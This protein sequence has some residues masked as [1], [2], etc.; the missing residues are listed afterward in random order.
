MPIPIAAAIAGGA[1]LGSAGINAYS[2]GKTNKATRNYNTQMYNKQRADSMFDWMMQNKRED[3]VWGRNN[4]YNEGLWNKQNQYN[5]GLWNKQ[6]QYD[7]PASQMQRF[8]E[9]GLNPNLIYGQSNGGGTIATAQFQSDRGGSGEKHGVN[10]M[11][12]NPRAPQFDLQNGLLAY[13]QQRESA[14]RINNMESQNKILEQDSILRAVQTANTAGRTAKDSFELGLASDLRKTS[15]QAAEAALRKTITETDISLS[16]NER[17]AAMNSSNLS[18][19]AQRIS[20]MRGTQLN[21]KLDA[22]LKQMDIDMKGLGIER[23]DNMFLRILGRIFNDPIKQGISNGL[24]WFS[25]K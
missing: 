2:Q 1:A 12:Y 14:A 21:Q 10:A 3:E 11:S 17:E 5:E 8:K 20:T 13:T 4:Q 15:V 23:T 18:E 19:A 22:Q 16:R 25:E 24:D 9:A 7:S 6:N